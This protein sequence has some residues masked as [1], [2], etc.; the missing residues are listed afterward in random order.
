M[1]IG[2]P[3]NPSLGLRP[4]G[5]S[6]IKGGRPFSGIGVNHFA[7]L[8][9]QIE[10]TVGTAV[11]YS[12]DM[13]AIKRTYGLPFIRFAAGWYSRTTWYNRWYL[14]KAA[15]FAKFDEIVAKAEELNLGLF[16]CLFWSLRYF[17]DA[18]YDV[19]GVRTPPSGMAKPGNGWNLAAEFITDVV[20]RYKDSPAIW[21]WDLHNE[22]ISNAG[23][24]Y[25]SSWLLDGTGTDGFANSLSWLNWG[26][27]P[28]GGTYPATDKMSMANYLDFNNKA[29]ALIHSIDK[30]GRMITS[31]SGQGNSFAVTTQTT[32]SVGADTL[33]QW[34]TA[35]G[36]K[37][38]WPAY[39]D[40]ESTVM[41]TH[42]YPNSTSNALF[43]TGGEKTAAEQI[44]LFK[45]WADAAS[46][47][48]FLQEFGATLQATPVDEIS[49]DLATE[50]ANFN[51]ILT[52][53]VSNNIQLSA[54]WNY[55]GDLG[56]ANE[57]QLWKM[58]D[59]TKTY[60]LDA[61]AVANAS[62]SN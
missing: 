28:E 44:A 5:T 14:A 1:I 23:P 61:I 62:M 15:Y 13:T 9:R 26:T 20:S 56:G 17:S 25:H 39:R 42:Q 2:I 31:G 32:N 11:D 27:K 51:N 58:S 55:G 45:G 18:T 49:T 37:P 47:P 53:I 16:P 10:P 34:N 35:I 50:T 29:R 60:Q 30:S 8:L 38:N 54:A 48:F 24:E 46:I 40:R 3:S 41:V 21:G 19:Y 59:P 22:T 6:F 33:A 36:G 43:F 12:A 4:S 57:W 7:L 52:A